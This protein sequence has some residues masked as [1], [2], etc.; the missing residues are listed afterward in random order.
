M[1]AIKNWPLHPIHEHNQMVIDAFTAKA[2]KHVQE[3][4]GPPEPPKPLSPEVAAMMRSKVNEI[5]KR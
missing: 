4:V 2:V 1:K 5:F 3:F